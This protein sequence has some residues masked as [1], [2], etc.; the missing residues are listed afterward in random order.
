LDVL[1]QTHGRTLFPGLDGTPNARIE[2]S[3]GEAPLRIRSA[4][5]ASL[6]CTGARFSSAI[7][8]RLV[9]HDAKFTRSFDDVFG[10]EGGQVLCTP[11]QAPKAN[12]DAERW[13]QSV[14]AECLDW[15]LMLGRRHLRWLLRGY[16][17]HYHQRR[18]HRGLALAVPEPEAQEERSPQVNPL[19]LAKQLSS[20]RRG[21]SCGGEI[22]LVG[23]SMNR[24]RSHE[25]TD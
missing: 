19:G 20:R 1:E 4:D 11:I 23:Y 3:D 14:R 24:R 10:S 8:S 12:A 21:A 16:V 2:R 5:Q 6:R 17:C 7:N 22:D 13:V 18:P 9:D 15:T 25:V